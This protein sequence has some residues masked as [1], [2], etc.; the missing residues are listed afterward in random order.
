MKQYISIQLQ[1][2]DVNYINGMDL[3]SI[4]D[5][6]LEI[7][8]ENE[9][10]GHSNIVF[11]VIRDWDY[12]GFEIWGERLEIDTEHCQRLEYEEKEQRKKQLLDNKKKEKELKELER[13]KKKYEN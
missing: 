6:F 7:K 4:A 9:Q 8:K 13:L 11:K 2:F 1:D 10:S 12:T 3:Q 5:Y